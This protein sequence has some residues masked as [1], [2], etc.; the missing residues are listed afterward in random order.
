M[1]AE[2]LDARLSQNFSVTL[3]LS[4][5]PT[6]LH[7]CPSKEGQ[8]SAAGMAVSSG[9]LHGNQE[10]TSISVNGVQLPAWVRGSLPCANQAQHAKP[11]S[12][13][14]AKEVSASSAESAANSTTER[15]SCDTLAKLTEARHTL[16]SNLKGMASAEPSIQSLTPSSACPPDLEVGVCPSSSLRQDEQQQQSHRKQPRNAQPITCCGAHGTPNDAS[17]VI[18]NAVITLPS[19]DAAASAAQC[20]EM[21]RQMCVAEAVASTLVGE[22]GTMLRHYARTHDDMERARENMCAHI[23][24]MT[25]V[26]NV[27]LKEPCELLTCAAHLLQLR[28]EACLGMYCQEFEH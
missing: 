25:N 26:S 21:A 28:W 17:R 4:E 7:L 23:Q 24:K 15:K 12:A 18:S 20:E 16:M 2:G 14:V 1:G 11:Q 13:A 5:A 10:A 3:F 22:L 6:D 9:G 8:P 27:T 19:D